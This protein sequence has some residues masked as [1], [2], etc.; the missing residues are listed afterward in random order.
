M[1]CNSQVLVSILSIFGTFIGSLVGVIIGSY[2]NSFFAIKSTELHFFKTAAIKFRKEIYPFYN[3]IREMLL[4]D[5]RGMI[6]NNE[7]WIYRRMQQIIP[8]HRK[9]IEEFRFSIPTK[10]QLRFNN[11]ADTYCPPQETYTEDDIKKMFWSNENMKIEMSKRKEI[12]DKIEQMMNFNIK[13]SFHFFES[14]KR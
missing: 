12:K 3:E 5:N 14:H 8:E 9:I 4:K 1:S 11:I 2:F 6:G 10:H 7:T 13:E